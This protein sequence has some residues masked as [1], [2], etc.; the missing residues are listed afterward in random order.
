MHKKLHFSKEL[1]TLILSGKKTSTWRLWD[2][3]NLQMGNIVEFL[4]SKTEK[5]FAKAKIVKVVEKKMGELK[6]SDKKGHEEFKND[7]EM[8]ETYSRYYRRKVTPDTLV[9]IV[10]FEL[11]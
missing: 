7:N 9:K 3:K 8:Y 4:E 5:H 6:K 10:W 2:D 11:I 1:V